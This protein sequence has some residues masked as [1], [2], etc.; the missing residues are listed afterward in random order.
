M[1]PGFTVSYNFPHC[2]FLLFRLYN[3]LLNTKEYNFI[4]EH[5]DTYQNQVDHL[6]I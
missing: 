4:A 5:S 1:M 3:F 6:K 2:F